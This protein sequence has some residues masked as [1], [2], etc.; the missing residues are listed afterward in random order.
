MDEGNTNSS[1]EDIRKQ[2]EERLRSLKNDQDPENEQAGDSVQNVDDQI[3]K[4]KEKLEQELAEKNRMEKEKLEQ[5][6]AEKARLEKEKMEQEL[7]ERMRLEK[8]KLDRE[9]A[10]KARLEKERIEQKLAE[11]A[12]LEK[13]RIE[14]ELAEKA[15]LE[16]ERLEKERL[17][18]ERLEKERFEKERQE[19]ERLERE[20]A[21]KERLEKE[22]LEKERAENERLEKEKAEKERLE[23]ERQEQ[24]RLEKEKAEEERAEKERKEKE[25]AEK[26]KAEKEKEEQEKRIKEQ[27][28]KERAEKEK[29]EKEKLEKIRIQKEK[30][31]EVKKK[32]VQNQPKKI[33]AEKKVIKPEAVKQKKR[34]SGVVWMILFFVSLCAVGYLGYMYYIHDQEL[35]EYRGK[36]EKVSRAK[37]S[38]VVDEL[39]IIQE[40]YNALKT[41]DE[42]LLA[43]L[44]K[45][46]E[47]INI[48]I[49][50][51][52]TTDPLQGDLGPYKT[53]LDDLRNN[54]P[55][56]K[57]KIDSV[58]SL[59]PEE[60]IEEEQE[61]AEEQEKE[62]KTEA[63]KEDKKEDKAEAPPKSLFKALD[64]E[65]HPINDAGKIEYEL[66]NISEIKVC[67]T[68]RK[69]GYVK[70]GMTDLYLRI[71]GPGRSVLKSN[72]GGMFKMGGVKISF[73]A[74]TSANYQNKDLYSCISYKVAK[75]ELKPGKYVADIF[76]KD[77]KIG[78]TSFS[79]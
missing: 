75:N 56:L 52:E 71:T 57:A 48:Y 41:D 23:Q 12:R 17:E 43:E 8:E 76:T 44:N 33:H 18:K 29:F 54:I 40:E 28:E 37:V 67:F 16:K 69:N 34:S 11:K 3:I 4:E 72:G 70:T 22:R 58:N 32:E 21:E 31:A 15:R 51:L 27:R 13:E 47:Q 6:L 55:V 65:A 39:I 68:L 20:K 50:D 24:E 36:E 79:R 73:S 59:P 60:E 26:E 7:E 53:I 62:E 9:F 2:M 63:K 14:K 77:G 38:A 35:K 49:E 19:K 25:K 74:K 66:A 61:E 30:E 10:E 45:T 1:S 64:I 46:D 78:T 5:E 42:G